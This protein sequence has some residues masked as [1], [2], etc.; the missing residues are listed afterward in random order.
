MWGVYCD[1]MGLLSDFFARTENA[2]TSKRS[3]YLE[4][5][6]GGS[7]TASGVNVTEERA[8]TTSAVYACV[9]V[10]SESIASLPLFLYERQTTGGKSRARQHYL[11]QLL[12]DRPNPLMTAFE[13][14][15]L[16]VSH[17]ALY[18]NAYC[19]I[20][21]N[22]SG[23]I[24]EL[25]PLRPDR[26]VQIRRTES[27]RLAYQYQDGNG[28]SR[29]LP[30]DAVWHL[31]GL[32]PD[33][34]MGYS[35]I[36]LMRQAVGMSLATEEFGARFFQ[37]GARPSM[38]L[39]HP[40]VLSDEAYDRLASSWMANYGG[41]A[42]AHRPAILE[43]G[44]SVEAIGLPPEDAQFLETRRYQLGE[45]ARIYRIPPHMIGDLE[46]ATFSNIEHQ[47]INFVIHTLRPWLVR[48]E[49]SISQQLLLERDRSRYYAEFL[50]DGLLR[51]D[52]QSRYD[53]YAT[54]RQNGWLSADDIRRLENMNPLPDGKGDLYLVPLNM[55][56][57]DQL[58]EI[59]EPAADEAGVRQTSPLSKEAAVRAVVS[60]EER[61]RAAAGSRQR[62]MGSYMRLFEDVL[63]RLVRREVTDV[64]RAARK[65]LKRNLAEFVIWLDQYYEAHAETVRDGL[66]P[67][68]EA[69]AAA[70]AE[71]VR[72]ELK[73]GDALTSGAF[74]NEYANLYGL[75]YAAARQRAV[76]RLI[77]RVQRDGGELLDEIEQ[78]FDE[79]DENRPTTEARREA[80]RANN[81]FAVLAYAA[82]GVT[83]KRWTTVGEDC[84]YCEKLNG[85]IVEVHG[86]FL[87][88]GSAIT[89]DDKPDMRISINMGHPPAHDGCD[90]MVTA[91]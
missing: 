90:C 42:N 8:L 55:V 84:P 22:S 21:Y 28:G 74:V 19:E 89:V 40:G 71:Q 64:K 12:H 48:I 6:L 26:M 9:R 47:S 5:M 46:R 36:Q 7:G 13:L 91:A 15:E 37:N 45:I 10:L 41:L 53:A 54:G 14:R 30:Q 67:T 85:K 34:I 31:R 29:W 82:Y 63:A 11:Y 32:S 80:H 78:H 60:F 18:G 24:T 75:R 17:M 76:T 38:V 4:A 49:Q 52:I 1:H 68:Y 79:L 51:G 43:E 73:E 59:N 83:R 87:S 25:W 57:V 23:R 88:A 16:L 70:V 27:N 66:R 65:L 20:G 61:S 2:P 69:Y 62:V 44:M 3:A 39:Q 35:P 77:E 86:Y 33:G 56:P 58:T 81:A 72:L 50:V